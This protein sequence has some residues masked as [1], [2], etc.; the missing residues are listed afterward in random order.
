MVTTPLYL[1]IANRVNPRILWSL[2]VHKSKRILPQSYFILSF[3]CDTEEDIAVVCDVHSRL[4]GM[5]ITPVYAVPG[6]LLKKGAKV[7][8]K[9]Y[10]T[11]AEFINHGG[12]E[13][14]Y[15][16]KQHQR[17]ASCFFYDQQTQK[18]LKKDVLLGHQTLQDVLGVTTKGW[19]TPHFGTFQ[20]P[21]DLKFLYSILNELSYG[22]STSTS[23][24]M[25]Y[26]HGPLFK[27]DGIIEIPITGMYSEPLNIMD[28]W[29]YFE[30]P[31]RTKSPSEYIKEAHHLAHFASQHPVLI[32]I[33]GDP[34][35]IYGK[36]EFFD[37]MAL[38]VKTAQNVNYMQLLEKTYENIRTIS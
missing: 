33:Y 9:I 19:R 15:F 14:T 34:S 1:K 12:C 31:D 37:V 2:Y 10:E 5:G 35:H 29:A 27:K 6:E 11:G 30:A 18:D 32:N 13:H 4:Q 28:T 26:Q 22:F 21:E 20:K 17:H 7:Y 24:I 38:L 25:T 3:D 23:P 16:D 36:S 8:K